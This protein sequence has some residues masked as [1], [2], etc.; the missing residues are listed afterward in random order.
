MSTGTD[1]R[2][3]PKPDASSDGSEC[4]GSETQKEKEKAPDWDCQKHTHRL[5]WYQADMYVESLG[6]SETATGADR[7]E[8]TSPSAKIRRKYAKR[9]RKL[10]RVLLKMLNKTT[11]AGK[12]LLMQIADDFAEDKDC[13]LY[14]S[15]SPRDS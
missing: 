7:D 12:T 2:S 13:L 6:L 9:N 11:V 15:P 4:S 3:S 1:R 8:M 14:T 10:F 5:W